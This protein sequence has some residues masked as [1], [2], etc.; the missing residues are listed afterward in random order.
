MPY[1]LMKGLAWILLALVLGIVIGWAAAHVVAKRQIARA[2]NHHVDTVEMERLRGRVAN[3]E[4]L[5]AERDRLRAELDTASLK[6]T[7]GRPAS[8]RCRRHVRRSPPPTRAG[9]CRHRSPRRSGPPVGPRPR[10]RRRGARA[11]PSRSTTSRSSR[12]SGPK[13]EELCHGIGIRTWYDL[14]TTEVSLLRTMLADAGPRFRTHDPGSWPEQARL[15]AEGAGRSSRRSPTSL[16]GGRGCRAVRRNRMTGASVAF[17]AERRGRRRCA[18]G[19]TLLDALRE[20][21]G[22]RSVKDGCSPQGQCGCCT[23]W[24]DGQ[25]RV[26]CVTP[27]RP[28]GR[29]GGHD[30]RGPPRR[31]RVGDRVLR[32]RRQPVRVLHARG[33]SCA[34]AALAADRRDR[35]RRCARRCSPTCA[36]ARA[37]SR[38]SSRS[39]AVDDGRRGRCARSAPRA[40]AG[41]RLEGGVRAGGRRR[42]SRSAPAASPTT[43]RRPDALV[44]LRERWRRVGGG[45]D[46][47]RGAVARAARCRAGAP[48]HRSLADRRCPRAT[49]RAR[50][51]PRGSSPPT[52]NPTRRGASR[53]ASRSSSHGNGGAFGGKASGELGSVR[54]P[55]GRRARA[56]GARA[57]HPRGRRAVR[58][59]AAADRGRHP[60]RR[61]GRGPR[62][63]HAGHRRRD[64]LGRAGARGGGGRRRR[65]ADV[66]GAARRRVG[67][68]GGAARG[69]STTGPAHGRRHRAAG[70][71]RR[72]ST[73]TAR[74]TCVSPAATRS[75]RWCCAATAPAPRTWRSAGSRR[76][77][78]SV[79]EHGA[80]HDLTIR[81]FGVLRAVD[82]PRIHVEIEPSRRRAGERQRR[83]VR[84]VVAAAAWAR[85]GWA[86]AL[87]GALAS[88]A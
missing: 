43:S 64:P 80:P 74:S 20:Q 17:D 83:G 73:T 76:R 15:L 27:V 60:R 22:V 2:R 57:R 79:D 66:G 84:R 37:G 40:S 33:S 70:V 85:S 81:S 65:P 9:R 23:V 6:R 25:P 38:S 68:G 39:S 47:R 48:R 59:E 53:A 77:G 16:D 18:A 31:R 42:R 49:G 10:R 51:A 61:L 30:G 88:D 34:C 13:I 62:R 36:G 55:A 75:T 4:P 86:P 44:A 78:S 46:A 21:L 32:P 14:S 3:L 67:G 41:P 24:V 26:S 54:P 35:R 50:C 45:R 5:V 72:R 87:A 58:P 1:T 56:A 8:R 12:A 52:S 11:V 82:T 63:A 71:R 28:R 69:R 19:G 29:P 7:K